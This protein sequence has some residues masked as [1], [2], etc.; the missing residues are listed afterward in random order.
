VILT[1]TLYNNDTTPRYN[2]VG[3]CIDSTP[4]C[5]GVVSL[6]C[7][8]SVLIISQKSIKNA[9]KSESN[10]IQNVPSQ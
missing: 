6:L 2:G 7:S 8:L 4:L 3:P 1:L 5:L 10:H 9:N